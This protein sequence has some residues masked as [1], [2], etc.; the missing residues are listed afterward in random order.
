MHM[1]AYLYGGALLMNMVLFEI[2][3]M[4][5]LCAYVCV[6][7]WRGATNE[8]GIDCWYC[9][10]CLSYICICVCMYGGEL[11]F[12]VVL[13]ISI[14]YRVYVCAHG[15]VCACTYAVING[16]SMIII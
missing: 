11:L 10:C 16:N 14:M 7:A 15:M 12:K 5:H 8:N 2:I 13:F 1:C 6:C 4:S 3:I 9:Y